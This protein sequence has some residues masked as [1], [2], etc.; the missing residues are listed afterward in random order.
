M[1]APGLVDKILWIEGATS[2]EEVVH[3][4]N[5]AS[6]IADGCIVE[7]GSFRGRSTAA[8]AIGSQACPRKFEIS[9]AVQS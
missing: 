6:R 2:R 5:F 7:I 9:S 1:I 4:H 8:L 3:L